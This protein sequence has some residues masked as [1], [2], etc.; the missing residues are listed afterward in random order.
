[1]AIKKIEEVYLYVTDTGDNPAENI[2]A[3]AFMEKCGIPYI[4]MY[5]NNVEQVAEVLQVMNGWWNRPELPEE[6]RMPNIEKMP[7]VCYTEVHDDIPARFSPVKYK[8]GIDDIKTFPE[9]YNSIMN[10]N[11]SN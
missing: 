3:Q 6:I 7:F 9:F 4:R 1:M 8:A 5:Y 10:T 11:N 2:Q